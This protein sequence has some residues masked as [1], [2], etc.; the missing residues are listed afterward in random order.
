MRIA[1]ALAAV[2]LALTALTL[3]APASAQA[4]KWDY[5]CGYYETNGFA[6]YGHCTNDGSWIWIYVD[7]KTEPD[8]SQC[9]LPGSTLLDYTA[10]VQNAWYE[11]AKCK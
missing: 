1:P 6:Y 5:P 2:A 3:P 4:M 10:K 8:Y 11:G 9:V 7:R